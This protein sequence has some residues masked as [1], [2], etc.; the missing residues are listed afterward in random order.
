MK[1]VNTY[2][3]CVPDLMNEGHSL[4]YALTQGDCGEY[5]VYVG[6]VRLPN[7]DDKD[8]NNHRAFAAQMVMHHGMPCDY[9]QAQLCFPAISEQEYRR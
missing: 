4:M 2:V 1:V 6:M 7:S 3:P 5:K 8:Y 9:R